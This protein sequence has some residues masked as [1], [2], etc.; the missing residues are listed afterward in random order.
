MID[1]YSVEV[2]YRNLVCSK[3]TNTPMTYPKIAVIT[4][5]SSE[6]QCLINSLIFDLKSLFRA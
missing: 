1:R 6:I 4:Q 2:G 5:P 3:I